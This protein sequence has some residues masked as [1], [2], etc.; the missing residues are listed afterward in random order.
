MTRA[1]VWVMTL[2]A[3]LPSD[4]SAQA[5]P[6][7][8]SSVDALEAG[9]HVRVRAADALSIEGVFL[10]L[11]G[12]DILLTTTPPE[13]AQR[14]PIDPLVRRR[15]LGFLGGFLFGVTAPDVIYVPGALLPMAVGAAG[16]AVAMRGLPSRQRRYVLWSGF[17]GAV[18]GVV[19]HLLIHD[20]GP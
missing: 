16:V 2:I 15:V 11:E 17:G 6:T 1:T 8:E 13:E 4:V 5:A 3:V 19:L 14:V 12:P 20:P 10:E 7:R 18:V 9:Q